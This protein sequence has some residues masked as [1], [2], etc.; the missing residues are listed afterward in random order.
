MYVLCSSPLTARRPLLS[1]AESQETTPSLRITAVPVADLARVLAAAYGRRVD[2][3]QV[4][5]VAEAGGLI[6][7]DG[8]V[9]LI[10]YVAYLAE[11]VT[12]AGS[13]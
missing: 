10:E 7:A 1:V 2:E 12:G 3:A 8:T 5:Q 9:N 4:R 13:D 11:E 6:R